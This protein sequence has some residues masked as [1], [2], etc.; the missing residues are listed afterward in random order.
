MKKFYLF[1]LVLVILTIL[2]VALFGCGPSKQVQEA[3]KPM[4]IHFESDNEQG[5]LSYVVEHYTTSWQTVQSIPPVGH[6]NI[7]NVSIPSGSGLY[8]IRQQETTTATFTKSIN[9]R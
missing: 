2:I 5:V 1:W 6:A 8:R 7:Y 9:V 3:P 4:T